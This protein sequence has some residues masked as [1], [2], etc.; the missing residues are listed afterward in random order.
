MTIHMDD[1]I[2]KYSA[3]G[4]R[5]GAQRTAANIPIGGIDLSVDV[6]DIRHLSVF[7]KEVPYGITEMHLFRPD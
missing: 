6:Y 1:R 7:N 3:K 2:G 5:A 4:L